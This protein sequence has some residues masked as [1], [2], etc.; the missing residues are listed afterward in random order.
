MCHKCGNGFLQPLFSHMGEK[1]SLQTARQSLSFPPR[2]DFMCGPAE[3][4]GLE[5]S[6]VLGSLPK[7]VS[8]GDAGG[9]KREEVCESWHIY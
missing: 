6:T 3:K 5:H 1:F 7:A 2:L 8:R 4:H 9:V